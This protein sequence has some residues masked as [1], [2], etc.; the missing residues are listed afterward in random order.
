MKLF[1]I[2]AVC[3][4]AAAFVPAASAAD[5]SDS[6]NWAGYA[7]ARTDETSGA[8][9]SFRAVSGSWTQPAARCAAGTPSY[10]AF[11]IGIGGAAE[12]SHALEQIGTSSDCT[13]AGKPV[14]S[15]WYELVPAA[16]VR[17]KVIVR[18]GDR[19]H[20]VVVVDGSAVTMRLQNLT[21]HTTFTKRLTMANPDLSS[22]EWIAEAPSLCN[23]SGR[24]RVL[25]LADFGRVDFSQGLAV[26]TDGRTGAIADSQWDATPIRLVPD[27][28]SPGGIAVP[29]A[30]TAD[31]AG[32][33][34]SRQS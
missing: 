9:A 22:A 14:Y 21:R 27:E 15:L 3:A 33:S 7:I 2:G 32:F 28:Q 11:W 29:G 24:C 5:P 16:S 13:A 8:P 25:P 10:S 6:S 26:T 23:G 17:T 31:G 34:V 20:A 30:L 12:S 19:L 18:P 4:L 1:A